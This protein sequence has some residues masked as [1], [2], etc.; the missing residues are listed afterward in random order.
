MTTPLPLDP[1]LA[2]PLK[3]FLDLLGGGLDLRDVPAFRARSDAIFA[4]AAAQEPDVAG[5]STEDMQIAGAGGAPAVNV[6]LYLPTA[7][8]KGPRAALLWIHGGGYVLGNL[9]QSNLM[10][11][12]LAADTGIAMLAVDYRLAPEH[13]YPAALEDCYA[14]LAFLFERAAQLR[15]DPERIAIGGASAGGGLT[16]A[17]ALLARE[18]GHYRPALQLL[19]YPMI[20]DTNVLPVSPER[21]DTLLWTR[22]N[23]A[24]AWRCYLGPLAGT[25]RIPATAAPARATDLR[26]LP[27]AFIPV[28]TLD[29]FLQE[30]IAY[31]QRL[32]AAGVSTELHVYPG[33]YHAFDAFAPESKLG[34]KF[35]ADLREVLQR[36]LG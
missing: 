13:P 35:A 18:R 7:A 31:A 11:K 25:G 1:E 20:D 32:L 29:L 26:G 22:A 12:Q 15:L 3:F 30:D 16:A 21:P 17:L 34:R 2:E 33:A 10:L 4:G 27:P 36:A 23:N 5:V 9:D 6:R 24:D 19:F 8:S 14:A 28:G